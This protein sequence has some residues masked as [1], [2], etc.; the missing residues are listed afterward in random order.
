M[1]ERIKT[2][3]AAWRQK[4]RPANS[5]TRISWGGQAP[6]PEAPK[7]QTGSPDNLGLNSERLRL[8]MVERVRQ[9]GVSDDKVLAALA[10]VPRHQF[11]DQAFASRAYE[12]DALPIGHGQTISQPWVVARMLAALCE[13][14]TPVR[15]LEVG[16]GCGYQAAVMARLFRHVFTV[17][18]VRPLYDMAK[19]RL[20]PLKLSNVQCRFGD[21]M[22]GWPAKA[23]FDGIIVA[24]AGLA[25]PQ[26]LLDQLTVGGKLIAPEGD[27]VQRLVV[28]TRLSNDRWERVQL[29]VVRF[30]PLKPG[31]QV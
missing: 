27:K 31:T 8:R 25:I 30:V 23:P 16:T 5:N 28:V 12:N 24:A 15:V 7:V 22:L 4:V 10:A 18:R 13:G 11:V 1:A 20:Q 19:A 3:A 17:E 14:S 21:G 2:D 6:K 9:Q 29:E 26:T